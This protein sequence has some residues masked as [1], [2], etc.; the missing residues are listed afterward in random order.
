MSRR[1][2][3]GSAS[4]LLLRRGLGDVG[5][6]ASKPSATHMDKKALWTQATKAFDAPGEVCAQNLICLLKSTGQMLASSSAGRGARVIFQAGYEAV[7]GDI[8]QSHMGKFLVTERAKSRLLIGKSRAVLAPTKLKGLFCQGCEG[9]SEG[10]R[11][12][13]YYGALRA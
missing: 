2:Q 5:Y 12:G 7:T 1:E 4:A 11:P 8:S 10:F 13:L 3:G 9:G 6:T